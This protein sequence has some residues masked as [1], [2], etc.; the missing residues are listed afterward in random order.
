MLVAEKVAVMVCALASAGVTVAVQVDTPAAAV[1]A[2]V[3]LAAGVNTSVPMPEDNATLP[4]GNDRLV[5][6]S[7]SVTVTVTVLAW[8]TTTVDGDSPTVV[9]VCRLFTVRSE[10][11]LL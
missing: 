8:L 6:A 7:S 3:Q 10:W 2:N 11:P 5:S 9:V 4:V 1:D